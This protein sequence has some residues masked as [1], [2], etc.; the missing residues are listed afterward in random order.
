MKR[1]DN[2]TLEERADYIEARGWY[3]YTDLLTLETGL[4]KK[5]QGR[6]PWSRQERTMLRIYM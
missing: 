2:W 5:R 3:T 1:T 4:L 6:G